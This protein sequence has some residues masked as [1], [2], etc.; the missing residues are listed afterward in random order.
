MADI[1]TTCTMADYEWAA[2]GPIPGTLV[3]CGEQAVA[4]IRF[5]CVHEHLDAA[6]ACAGCAADVQQESGLLA[7]PRCQDGPQPHDCPARY[8]IRWVSGEVTRG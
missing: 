1:P 2:R 4:V 3:A 5:A 8:E 6:A 7:C